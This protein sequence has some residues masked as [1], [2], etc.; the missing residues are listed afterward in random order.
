MKTLLFCHDTY[1]TKNTN[2]DIL[3]YGNFPYRLWEERYLPHF[4]ALTIIG[5]K[6]N[7]NKIN[8]AGCD[9]SSGKNVAHILLDN[10]NAPFKRI[11]NH[12]QTYKRI[13][14]EVAN[15]DGVIIR[16]PAEFGMIA[17]KA[18][19]KLE[20]PYAIE[21][22]GCAFDHTW[23]HGSLIGKIY[24]PIKYLRARHMVKHAAQ[25]IYVTEEFLQKRY[26]TNG[27]I[28]AAS[29]V[30]IIETSTAIL[31]ARINR[32]NNPTNT[33]Q[34]G[35][36]GNYGNT[37]KGIDVAIKALS[38]VKKRNY[39]FKLHI[40]GSGN[41]AKWDK[42]IKRNDLSDDIMFHDHRPAGEPVLEWLDT[43]DLYIQPS[44]H[45]GLPRALIEAMS[46][47]LPCLASNAGGSAEL[48]PLEYIHHAGNH[49]E[50]TRHLQSIWHDK[51]RQTAA[52]QGN[53][54]RAQKYTKKHLDPIRAE[55]LKK[56]RK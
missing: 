34:I 13:T 9:I 28:A 31:T 53:F 54:S 24:A 22:S 19:R 2:G 14:A 44:R 38:A 27:I 47:A 39:A 10:I 50:L 18:A 33:L 45:E 3:A 21:M 37:L 11:M 6:Q 36:I 35:L 40:L 48:L 29:N 15:A 51:N 46:R 49:K 7:S 4:N 16:G 12:K 55:F 56:F 8:A 42:L 1:Y 52:A 5:R 25:V 41:P 23:H 43:L 30:E 32:I 20:K 26:P 17:A